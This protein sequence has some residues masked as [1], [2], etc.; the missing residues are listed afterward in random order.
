MARVEFILDDKIYNRSEA[1]ALAKYILT[2]H[3]PV[4]YDRLAGSEFRFMRDLYTGYY[5]SK[6]PEYFGPITTIRVGL[7]YHQSGNAHPAFHL[8]HR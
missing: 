3:N 8:L 2:T 7:S 1:E 5:P 6:K 4:G